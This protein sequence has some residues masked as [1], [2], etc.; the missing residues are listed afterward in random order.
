MVRLFS[1]T[2]ETSAAGAYVTFDPRAR[3][4]W[5]THPRGQV[6]IVTEGVGRVQAWGADVQEIRPG[7]VVRI[8][9]GQ[10]HWH[11]AGPDTA[12]THLAIQEHLNGAAVEW[13]EHVSDEQYGVAPRPTKSKQ[14]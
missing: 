13:M 6:L 10:K 12:M 11:G 2:D 5:H 4:A 7:D 3:T 14:H 1:A 8:A 9:P